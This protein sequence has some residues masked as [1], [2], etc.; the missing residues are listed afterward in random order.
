MDNRKALKEKYK[1][2]RPEM[3]V[4]MYKCIPTGKAYLGFDQNVKA[5]LNGISF[6]LKTGRYPVNKNLQDDWNKYGEA[7]FEISVLE[8]LEYDKDDAKT[9]YDGDLRVLREFWAEKFDG[10]EYIKK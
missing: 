1:Q 10:A 3:G 6:Q 4:F 7:G 2:M 9:D 8:I 5:T